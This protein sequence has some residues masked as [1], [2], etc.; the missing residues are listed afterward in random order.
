[1]LDDEMKPEEFSFSATTSV[2]KSSTD[3]LG[4][5]CR[6]RDVKCKKGQSRLKSANVVN[7]KENGSK[8]GEDRKYSHQTESDSSLT[9]TTSNEVPY[10]SNSI[11]PTAVAHRVL[12]ETKQERRALEE[13]QRWTAHNMEQEL[14]AKRAGV[15]M[16]VL[17]ADGVT[18]KEEAAEQAA[19]EGRSYELPPAVTATATV[20][21]GP[22]LKATKAPAV[23]PK[24][25][26][27][28]KPKAILATSIQQL[29]E[30]TEGTKQNLF[31]EPPQRVIDLDEMGSI[32]S[33]I[34]EE[35]EVTR[36]R[37][38]SILTTDNE[39]DLA[40]S[41]K[42]DSPAAS[43]TSGIT[44]AADAGARVKSKSV[45]F[46]EEVELVELYSSQE[47][48][49]S[50]A[51]TPI[52]THSEDAETEV[53]IDA[54]LE[55]HK[56]EQSK[57]A[58]RL[59]EAETSPLKGSLVP[60]LPPR[61][62]KPSMPIG[63]KPPPPYP[64]PQKQNSFDST[65]SSEHSAIATKSQ[66]LASVRGPHLPNGHRSESAGSSSEQDSWDLNSPLSLQKASMQF[67]R[68]P[69]LRKPGS[70]FSQPLQKKGASP[71]TLTGFQQRPSGAYNQYSATHVPN[72]RSSY[73]D[74]SMHSGSDSNREGIEEREWYHS[75]SEDHDNIHTKLDS[76]WTSQD[77]D[78]MRMEQNL[79][80][81][82]I[83]PNVGF[84]QSPAAGSSANQTAE[85]QSHDLPS[86]GQMVLN[87]NP[88][89][90]M[91]Q[92]Q[93]SPANQNEQSWYVSDSMSPA[94]K[95]SKVVYRGV[96]MYTSDC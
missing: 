28:P 55:Q 36:S 76:S 79:R 21:D 80:R 43:A 46:Q 1:M 44:P 25:P 81:V 33:A 77:S 74:N 17:N 39:G 38:P 3:G 32:L 75:D 84:T 35:S 70:A 27:K 9:S 34:N 63:Y 86:A 20:H 60:A 45:T 49:N 73:S 72:P 92:S 2:L 68:N 40:V 15:V 41:R 93:S 59:Q 64:G 7:S 48:V 22:D 24:P 26:P 18:S 65:A 71:S 88:A 52:P 19:P 57:L 37:S 58:S 51:S 54:I 67:Y 16:S 23:K 12:A 42:R 5:D 83:N 4:S 82:H 90:H 10:S 61:A 30:V 89:N 8:R 96:V 47:N 31:S 91:S 14:A 85:Q 94:A 78:I 13:M 95:E 53:D 6:K 62:K 87:Q 29:P 56:A 50:A 11:D 69:G 66:Q